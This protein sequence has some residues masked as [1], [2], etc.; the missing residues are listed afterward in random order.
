MSG[1]QFSFLLLLL[2]YVY[3]RKKGKTKQGKNKTKHSKNAY[4]K[5][6][7]FSISSPL[8]AGKPCCRGGHCGDQGQVAAPSSTLFTS[9]QPDVA[10]ES[11]YAAF[12]SGSKGRTKIPESSGR[13]GKLASADMAGQRERYKRGDIV[14]SGPRECAAA[15][16]SKFFPLVFQHLSPLGALRVSD[17]RKAKMPVISE[18]SK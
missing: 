18:K 15:G 10:V 2:L 8:R 9:A 16:W 17:V 11:A 4:T 1:E 13:R 12:R 5:D 6:S 7:K 14:I 3:S